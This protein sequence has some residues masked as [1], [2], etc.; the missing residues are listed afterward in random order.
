MRLE[1]A[2]LS[3]VYEQ[4]VEAAPSL[5]AAAWRSINLLFSNEQVTIHTCYS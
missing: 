2:L 4:L 5:S 1:L 3:T